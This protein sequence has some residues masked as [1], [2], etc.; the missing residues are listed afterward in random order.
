MPLAV[1]HGKNDPA[2][3]FS[4][5][6]Y[7]ATLFGEAGWPAFRF[8]ADD[9]GAGHMFA[10]L[11]VDQAIRWLE[12]HASI[13]SARLVD[14]AEERVKSEEGYRDAIAALNRA[15]ALEPDVIDEATL[16]RIDRLQDEIDTRARAG[17]EEFLPK[18]RNDAGNTWIDAFLAFRDDFEFASA[19]REVMQAFDALRAEHN[20]PAIKALG[21]ARAAFQQ[22]RREDGYAQYQEIVDRYYAASSYRNV[23]R[24]VAE[25][26]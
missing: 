16:A 8:F 11:P 18:I 12:A 14:F 20:G 1:I 3:S 9:S 21:D 24:R 5:G 23:K 15:R 25:R 10:R 13:D 17:A 4:T 2:V 7:A 19:A 22:G 6:T 26:E